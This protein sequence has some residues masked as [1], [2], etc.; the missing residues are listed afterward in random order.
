[1]LHAARD[2]DLQLARRD[3]VGPDRRGRKPRAAI[4]VDGDARRAVAEAGEERGVARDIV[5][6]RALRQPAPEHDVLHF[7]SLDPR[8]RDRVLEDVPGHRDA[9]CLVERA[10]RGLGDARA[11]IGNDG[12]VLHG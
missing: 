7:A 5:A 6:G 12:D 4:A 1:M 2:P 8:A 3:A 11:A 9:V 10:A